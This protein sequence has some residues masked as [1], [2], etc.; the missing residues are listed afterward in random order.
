[1]SAPLA[2][3]APV[4]P[5]INNGAMPASDTRDLRVSEK[6]LAKAEAAIL[7][8][9]RDVKKP[10][11]RSEA[12]IHGRLSNRFATLAI[13]AALIRLDVS[14]RVIAFQKANGSQCKATHFRYNPYPKVSTPAAD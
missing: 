14:N 7:D 3:L 1:M 6:T 9:L 2:P 10:M 11:H 8:I 5:P 4:T 12:W 13:V